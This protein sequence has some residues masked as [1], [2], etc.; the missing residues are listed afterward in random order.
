MKKIKENE[1]QLTVQVVEANIELKI[2][3]ELFDQLNK[4]YNKH[5]EEISNSYIQKFLDYQNEVNEKKESLKQKTKTTVKIYNLKIVSTKNN[6]KKK[7]KKF[8]N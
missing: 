6:W 8:K 7:P 2:R 1:H 3:K 4:S 5:I